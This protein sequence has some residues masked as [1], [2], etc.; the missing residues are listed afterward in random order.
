MSEVTIGVVDRLVERFGWLEP[1][2]Q[3]HLADN[4]GEVLPHLFLGDVT[5]HLVT[6]TIQERQ[7][8]PDE[9]AA[10]RKE[11]EEMLDALKQEF[12]AGDE[13]VEELITV[14][15]LENLPRNGEPGDALRLRLGPALREQLKRID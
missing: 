4:F 14:S 8:N 6:R 2:L 7:A 13:E 11:V 5:R 12:T 3:E 10:A 1:L 15:F 9:A